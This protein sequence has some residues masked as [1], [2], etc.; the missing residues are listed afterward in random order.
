MVQF[1][2]DA[3]AVRAV[4]G[5]SFTVQRGETVG[6]VGESGSGKSSTFHAIL[7]LLDQRRSQVSGEAVFGGVELLGLPPDQL[8]RFRG[9]QIGMV[10]QDPLS[11][12]D[13]VQRV[14]NQVVEALVVHRGIGAR[15]ARDEAVRLLELVGIP[16]PARRARQWPHEFS[17]GMR[18]RAMIAAALAMN[19]ALLVADEPT[20]ALDVTVQAQIL[21]LIANL[22]K[23]LGTSVV[24]I[25]HDLGVVAEQ[26]DRIMVMY[27]GRCV[28]IGT[29]EEVF[30]G[31]AHP[32]TRGLLQSLTQIDGPP[33]ERLRP[34]P[35][36]PPSLINLPS[37]C[38]FHPRCG[39]VMEP[40]CREVGPDLE[41]VDKG[42]SAACHLVGLERAPTTPQPLAIVTSRRET[43]R[44]EQP[45]LQLANLTKHFPVSSGTLS[46]RQVGAIHAVDGVTLDVRRGET[47][48]IVGES[49]C[50]KSTL[51][52][53]ILRLIEPTSGTI[54]LDGEDITHLRGRELRDKRLDIQMV[55]QDPYGSLNPR[56][57]VGTIIGEQLN[58]HRVTPRN[59]IK[60]QV[61]ELMKVVGL[62]PEHSNR[63][64]H[65]FSGG[66]RQRVGIARALA[67]RP[68]LIV[69]DE[70]VSA[71]DVSIQAQV[72][73]LMQDLQRQFD[74]TY[75]F[76]SH[77]LSVIHQV[78][79]RVAVMYMGKIVELAETS[80]LFEA[81]KHWYTVALLSASP[82]VAHR[83]KPQRRR[84]R[85]A[86][87]VPSTLQPPTGCR[88]HT[89][90][91]N[92]VHPTCST[93]EPSWTSFA[94]EHGAAC[95][96]PSE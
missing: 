32:Y 6:V 5:L 65:A 50:G 20:S 61:Q 18:Q 60:E 70:P 54:A 53:M 83:V 91:P 80:R 47:L 67:L 94:D 46:R 89:R 93:E 15:E 35:G 7:G 59:R 66:Q 75:M 82:S 81:P 19:P 30:D 37:G 23:E 45:I 87:D 3:G 17:G 79:D 96:Y 22:K 14:G 34:I 57:T 28:E 88:F 1:P 42:H 52:R 56:K 39:E 76:I 36:Q 62:N 31:S 21:E 4:D 10:F 68:K 72:L 84:I 9:S 25:T 55:F 26:C 40:L 69:A 48:G 44:T 77:D 8:R 74:V 78:A 64:P 38:V 92:A 29:S 2:T 63:F 12:L 95:H 24:L 51:A 41:V 85:I 27:A 86:G 16:Q 43:S 11:S 71:L 90:C 49:G 58:V 33:Q 13:P 73:N